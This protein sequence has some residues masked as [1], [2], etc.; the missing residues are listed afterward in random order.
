MVSEFPRVYSV[1]L[2]CNAPGQEYL[3]HIPL[4]RRSPLG[5]FEG[6]HNLSI[7]DW[8]ATFL[9][10]LHARSFFRLADSVRHETEVRVRNRPVPSL[11]RIECEC[12][13]EN[14]GRPHTIYTARA[15]DW[16]TIVRLILE[17]DPTVSCGAHSLVWREDLMHG[18]EFAHDPPLR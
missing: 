6:Q 2:D 8:P 12:A 16:N 18:T 7:G 5:I 9:C 10:L 1:N 11:W 4:P 15:P 17:R 3:C 13:H 14:C